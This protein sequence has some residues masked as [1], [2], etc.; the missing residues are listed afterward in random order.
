MIELA[1]KVIQLTGGKSKLRFMQLPSDDPRQRLPNI[2]LAKKLLDW[3]P[4]VSLDE[5][6][7]KTFNYYNKLFK[8]INQI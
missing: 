3:T 6:L 7:E 8:S 5:G 1:E 4:K 2:D